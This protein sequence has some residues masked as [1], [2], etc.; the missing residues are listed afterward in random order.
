MAFHPAKDILLVHNG[1]LDQHQTK[2]R[3]LFPTVSHYSLPQ[4]KGFSGGA[5]AGLGKLFSE[6]TEWVLFLTNDCQ[7]ISMADTPNRPCL[8]APLIWRRKKGQVDSLG[9][10]LNLNLAELR[11]CK[12]AEDFF[13]EQ[14][15][16]YVPGTAF[17]IHR[18]VFMASQG[19]DEKLGTY[20]EDVDLSLRLQKIGF[21]L[22]LSP[23]TEIIHS[24]GKTCHKDTHYTT[25]LYQRNRKI[26][27][28]RFANN[29]WQKM[30]IQK[31]L[32]RSWLK[33]MVKLVVRSDWGKLRLLW[34]AITD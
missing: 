28:L 27:C 5:N 22:Q 13:S 21:A 19:F 1:S 25:Y 30:Q 3:N 4:N 26:V 18:D 23:T 11:H 15:L 14:N 7:L 33:A 20:W 29:S 31:N 2:L 34:K 32:Y 12:T 9:G 8:S 10:K 17:W 24:V 16:S 6:D